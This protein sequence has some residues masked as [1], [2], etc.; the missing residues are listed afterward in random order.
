MKIL[1]ITAFSAGICGVWTRVLS[2]S[3]LLAK[4]HD[5]YVFSSNIFRGTGEDKI[6]KP[7]EEINN[8]KIKRF[9]TFF[10][11]GE[12][13]FF[14]NFEK[15]ALKLKP[16]LIITHAYRQY[17]S[18]KAL[19]IAKKLNISCI[20][21]THA[22]FLDKKLRS[23][24][25]NLAVFLYDNFIGKRIINS[26][27]KI[28]AI[29]NWE[30]PYLL[31]LNTKR[32]N[33][34]LIPNGIPDEFF[35]LKKSKEE[36]KILFLGRV[37]PIKDLE[38]LIRA[39]KYIPLKLDIVGPVEEDYKVKLDTL[40]KSLN[41][42]N[43]KFLPPIYDLK[44]KIKLIDNHEIFILPSK[45]EAMPQSLIE[46]MARGKIVI[47]SNNPGGEEII[48]DNKNGFLFK[49][50]DY[51]ELS[52]LI[53]KIQKMKKSQKTKIKLN[54]KNFAKQFSWNKLIKKIENIYFN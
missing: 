3:E 19:N 39:M 46:A 42:K 15:Q 35:R 43:V 6:A 20:L 18:T 53:N 24:K 14:W 16:D 21:V 47:S 48:S 12:N 41:L 36:N 49:I 38:T 7:Y 23:W 33:I 25:L 4:N 29:T 34:T 5:V 2:E 31:K 32:K 13:T 37:A 50:G 51:H 28:I 17:Y 27:N 8:I 44:G 40:I 52:K 22:P 1:E 10:N 45:R 26:Y 11:F 9:P 30:T 54:A